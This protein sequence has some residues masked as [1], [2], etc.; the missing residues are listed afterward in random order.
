[1]DLGE[2]QRHCPPY[3]LGMMP[4][5]KCPTAAPDLSRVPEPLIP[6]PLSQLV[7]TGQP[8]LPSFPEPQMK[9][10]LPAIPGPGPS[11]PFPQG[12][13]LSVDASLTYPI[14]SLSS[15]VHSGLTLTPHPSLAL[16]SQAP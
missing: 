16:L 2:E 11:T 7:E 14:S 13:S 3:M 5:P 4:I 9:G 15:H 6:P 10:V 8:F 12:L 1:M